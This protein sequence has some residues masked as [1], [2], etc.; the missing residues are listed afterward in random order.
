MARKIY[1]I[2]DRNYFKEGAKGKVGTFH[3]YPHVENRMSLTEE[4]ARARGS[5][6]QVH[7]PQ[8]LFKRQTFV[9]DIVLYLNKRGYNSFVICQVVH[10]TEKLAY[11]K[12][13][14]K[15]EP[16]IRLRV[17]SFIN[18]TD[19]LAANASRQEA[20]LMKDVVINKMWGIKE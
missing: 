4:D 11:A 16:L 19:Q 13:M 7:Y 18:I 3:F 9:N 20:L 10:C 8:D 12:A 15:D 6:L 5:F 17:G 1:E 14:G 2:D